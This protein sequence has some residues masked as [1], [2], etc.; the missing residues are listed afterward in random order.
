MPR[1]LS[2]SNYFSTL[3]F[4]LFSIVLLLNTTLFSSV[5]ANHVPP[6]NSEIVSS[7][8]CDPN[9]KQ[10][11]GYI[12]VKNAHYYFWFFESRNNPETSPL[13]LFLNG[14]PGCSSMI[15]LFQEMG[16]CRSIKNGT[17][18][19]INPYSWN[20][21]S[22][23]LFVDQPIGAG[24][25]Y[26]NKYLDSTEDAAEVLY[27]FL[28]L[29]FRQ[30]PEYLDRDFHLFGE[31]YAGHYVPATASLI[32]KKNSLYN[33]IKKRKAGTKLSVPIRLKSIGIGNGWI[34]PTIQYGSNI[35]YI[36][37]NAYG[38]LLNKKIHSEM[39]ANYPTCKALLKKCT[40]TNSP[41][42]CG[43]AGNYCTAN[44][45]ALFSANSGVN[46]YDVRTS[47]STTFSYPSPDYNNYLALPNV[48]KAIG[49]QIP[50]T[51]CSVTTYNYFVLQKSDDMRDFLPT[52]SSVVDSG[53]RTLMY[54]G[55]ADFDC[56]WMGGHNVS[57]AVQWK[58]QS[59]YNSAPLK[60]WFL[61]GRKARGKIQTH[62]CL[63]FVS[64]YNSGH[65]VSV[66]QPKVALEMFT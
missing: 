43:D 15:G 17:D 42:D 56:N 13:T 47:N 53:V 1:V 18:V 29:W 52:L 55:D 19:E 50:Y 25:S 4:A 39:T 65:E 14:G 21:V 12:K 36:I 62:S 10:Y 31:S 20:K 2:F 5:D 37:H 32:L 3:L 49:A 34:N 6:L 11:S 35:D 58:Y 9:V 23:L 51:E 48:R 30:F 8:I 45:T 7:N 28:Q 60:E 24:F 27:E 16:P 26:G 57:K 38:P 61:G 59:Q 22:N 66:Y 46:P 41:N 54:Y 33:N 64:I 44:F 40:D 63:T